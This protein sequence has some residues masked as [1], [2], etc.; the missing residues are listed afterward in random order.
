[1]YIFKFI[2]VE[3]NDLIKLLVSLSEKTGMDILGF[4]RRLVRLAGEHFVDSLL[5][6]PFKRYFSRWLETRQGYP[7]L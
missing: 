3:R 2:D 6:F 7:G 5:W 4:D 1:M